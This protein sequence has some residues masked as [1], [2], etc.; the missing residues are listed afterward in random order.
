MKIRIVAA[1][2]DTRQL[3]LYRAD[4]ESIT[5]KQGDQRLRPVLEQ[6]TPLIVAQGYADVEITDIT[7][8]TGFQKFEKQSG[9]VRFFK[10]AREKLAGLFAPAVDEAAIGKVPTPVPTL[11]ETLVMIN[12]KGP[13]NQPIEAATP[14]LGITTN[15]AAIDEIMRHAQPVSDA[16][17]NTDGLS[18]QGNVVEENGGTDRQRNEVQTSHTI[19]AEVGGKLIPNMERIETHF[20]RS[21]KL[22]NPG[23][24]EKF[25]Q[26][27][28]GVI[29]LRS[30][31]VEDLLKF[32]ERADMPVANDGSI[33]IYKVLKKKKDG[34]YVDCHS[35]NVP[36]KIGSYVCMDISLVDR[37]RNQ[38]CS[39]GLH[40]ARRGYIK[41]FSGDVC[42]IA[43]LAPE[44][45]VTVPAYD[46]NKMRVM[47]YHIL[48]ELSPA[49]Y[50][51]VKKNKPIT[52]L[53]EGKEL[54]GNVLAGRH[55]ERLEEV[56]ITG[57]MGNGVVITPI[58]PPQ[59]VPA[60]LT[61]GDVNPGMLGSLAAL[62]PAPAEALGN[63]EQE[64]QDTPINP[65]DVVK[66]VQGMSRREQ[67]QKLFKAFKKSPTK[68]NKDKLVAFKKSVK[69]GWKALGID[70]SEL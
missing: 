1:I 40:V 4:G 15:Q 61:V 17:F 42:M 36:Q 65:K 57:Q 3:T 11:A 26:R 7:V 50:A 39:N 63:P 10:V 53:D 28:A 25:L 24:V 70:E 64:K 46:A 44:D 47:G 37:N 20:N 48:A 30:H 16:D 6:V 60:Q 31:S 14:P 49:M 21:A 2:L 18:K 23:G 59:A 33:V 51:Q 45:V 19:V 66:N 29:D 52:D 8:V 38:E 27:L 56:R 12:D 5:I 58:T 41:E 22:G 69:L 62:E 32:M 9:L 35:G 34:H 43:K 55:V 54:L 67:A 68:K 13:F